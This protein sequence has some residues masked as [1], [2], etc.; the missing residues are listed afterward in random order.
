MGVE[1][2]QGLQ[3]KLKQHLSFLICNDLAFGKNR[4]K[5]IGLKQ[6]LFVNNI[7]FGKKNSLKPEICMVDAVFTLFRKYTI[8][9]V[10]Q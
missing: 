3:K 7:V 8:Y 9:C 5:T 10:R 6:L 2:D 4:T 1:A